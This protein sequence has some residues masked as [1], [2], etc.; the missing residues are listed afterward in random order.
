MKIDLILGAKP[1]KKC[2][3]KLA[4][5]YKHVVEKEIEGMLFVGIVY[6]INGLVPWSS[7]Q[8]NMTR[9]N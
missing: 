6:P 3:Y 7:N 1:I 2:P 8:R 9:R 4:H 5:K